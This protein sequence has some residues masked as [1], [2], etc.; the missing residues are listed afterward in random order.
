M[1]PGA[2]VSGSGLALAPDMKLAFYM[3]LLAFT[4]LYLLLMVKGSRIETL[5]AKIT[6]L[7]ETLR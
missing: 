1:H 6:A 3:S 4:L 5:R 7:K 2:I